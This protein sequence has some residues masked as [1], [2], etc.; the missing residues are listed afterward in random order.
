MIKWIRTS[1]LS[2]TNSLPISEFATIQV[3]R[4]GIDLEKDACV[5]IWQPTRFSTLRINQNCSVNFLKWP[6]KMLLRSDLATGNKAARPPEELEEE[7]SMW[8][9]RD[10]VWPHPSRRRSRG[11]RSTSRRTR[12]WWSRLTASGSTWPTTRYGVIQV[13]SRTCTFIN[14][15]IHVLDHF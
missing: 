5:L 13:G 3:S 7:T 6:V 14:T 2:M 11:L 10:P 4:V 15:L 12:S 9:R 8:T 1:R